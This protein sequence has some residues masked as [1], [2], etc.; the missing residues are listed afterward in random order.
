M[1]IPVGST[2]QYFPFSA[3]NQHLNFVNAMTYD[4]H[5]PWDST[6]LPN[7]GNNEIM[8]YLNANVL[9]T[10]LDPAKIMLGLAFYARVFTLTDPA[11]CLSSG[12][13]GC[14]F[15][16]SKTNVADMNTCTQTNGVLF[17]P[18]YFYLAKYYNVHSDATSQTSWLIT[19]NP[20]SPPSGSNTDLNSWNNMWVTYDTP[21]DIMTKYNLAKSKC[22]GGVMVWTIEQDVDQVLSVW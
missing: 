3:M 11:A 15:D 9:N 22:F 5:G 10:G 6:A 13:M 8:S 7:T 1:A 18:E 12:G 4:L 21:S 19:T 2:T 20:K 16:K 14:P 17:P